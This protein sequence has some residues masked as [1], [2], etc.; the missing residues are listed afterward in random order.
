MSPQQ[1]TRPRNNRKTL[2]IGFDFGT[3][4][5]KVVVRE[6]GI[7]DGR[8]AHFDEVANGYPLFASPSLVRQV[9]DRLFFGTKALHVRGG[10]LHRSLKV[11]LLSDCELRPASPGTL[12]NASLVAVYLTWAFQQIQK[13]LT[14]E[15][16]ANEFVNV[17]APMSH[18]EEPKLKKKY[19]QL[20]QAA[21][22]LTYDP[23]ARPIEQGI[24]VHDVSR[25]LEPLLTAPIQSNE[26]RRFDVLPE[27]IAP[28]V[29]L[30]QD[31]WM[32]PGMYMIIDMG[33]GT[34]EM[35]VFHTGEVGADQKV[36][37]Y[38]D[39]T[40]L[41]G[42]NDFEL[43][44]RHFANERIAQMVAQLKKQYCRIWHSGYMRDQGNQFA[45]KRWKE[46]TLVLSGGGTRHQA[47]AAGLEEVD[48]IIPWPKDETR[49]RSHRHRPGTLE[50]DARMDE[51]DASLFAVANGL[52]VE[53]KHWPIVFS[54]NQIPKLES[55]A[56]ADEKPPSYWYLDVK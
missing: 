8:I 46:L 51:A 21:W 25:L 33:A 32:E 19:L 6:R 44:E 13:S 11:N 12:G 34:T 45:R 16:Y 14:G 20:V 29:S 15:G 55:V 1:S 41:L 17:A 49:L 26:Q 48:P 35:S 3:H 2:I 42:G 9:D 10:T 22:K 52:A 27:T 56:E 50:I 43:A 47:V 4:S 5:T 30:S 40:M 54:P 31:P 38:R 37:C 53:R 28:V 24:P 39:E 18:Y 36:L 7:P 23:Q